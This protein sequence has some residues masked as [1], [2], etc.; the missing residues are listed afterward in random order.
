MKILK[1]GRLIR[2]GRRPTIGDETR[3]RSTTNDLM[4]NRQQRVSYDASTAL[5]PHENVGVLEGLSDLSWTQQRTE[6][7][8]DRVS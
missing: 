4:S 3:S 1:T 5:H 8:L 2:Q 7:V 6:P